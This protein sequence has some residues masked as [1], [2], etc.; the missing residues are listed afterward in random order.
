MDRPQEQL[1][2]VIR[3]AL[4]LAGDI[5]YNSAMVEVEISTGIRGTIK[6][7]T[8]PTRSWFYDLGTAVLL[9]WRTVL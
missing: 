7:N 5:P 2:S 3:Q 4:G 1:P 8:F 6:N 9:G